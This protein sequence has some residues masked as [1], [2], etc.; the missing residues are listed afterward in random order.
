MLNRFREELEQLLHD[1]ADKG[2]KLLDVDY[3]VV[4]VFGVD[5]DGKHSK[6][7]TIED[8]T[9]KIEVNNG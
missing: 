8:L 4:P 2:V 9:F 5:K 6:Y 1:Y 7:Y 3:E